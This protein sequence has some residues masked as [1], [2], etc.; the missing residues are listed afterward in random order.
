[1]VK[2]AN[3]GIRDESG[4][5]KNDA[6]PMINIHAISDKLRNARFIS[7]IDLKQAYCHIVL[8]RESQ[9]VVHL[10]FQDWDCSILHGCRSFSARTRYVSADN[11]L[12]DWNTDGT[13]RLRVFI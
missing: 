7:K 5:T 1:M 4:V 3:G 6:Y 2:K 11:W 9:E 13:A 10:L 8:T 12:A